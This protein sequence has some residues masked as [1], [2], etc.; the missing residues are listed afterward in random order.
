MSALSAI[1]RPAEV[2]RVL[3]VAMIPAVV[4]VVAVVAEDVVFAVVMAVTMVA[5]TV[6]AAAKMDMAAANLEHQPRMR[7]LA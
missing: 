2:S 4:V 5:V 3:A 6:A 1:R 7:R